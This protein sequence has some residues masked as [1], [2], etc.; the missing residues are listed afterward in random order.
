MRFTFMWLV[1]VG[2]GSTTPPGVLAYTDTTDTLQ[3]KDLQSGVAHSIAG[4]PYE[5]ISIDPTGSFVAYSDMAKNTALA[6]VS[7]G[8]VQPLE[9]ANNGVATLVEWGTGFLAYPTLVNGESN[10]ELVSNSG[11][12]IRQL[13]TAGPVAIAHDGSAIAYVQMTD[14]ATPNFTGTLVLEKPVGSAPTTVATN[15]ALAAFAFVDDDQYL[16]ATTLDAPTHALVIPLNGGGMTDLGQG[17]TVGGDDA[18]ANA[19]PDFNGSV[20]AGLAGQLVSVS[21]SDGVQTPVTTFPQALSS[22]SAGYTSTGDV[23]VNLSVDQDPDGDVEMLEQSSLLVSGGN[24]MMLASAAVGAVCHASAVSLAADS[25]ALECG[26]QD[27]VVK[28]T[29]GSQLVATSGGPFSFLGFGDDQSILVQ[30][31]D[32]GVVARVNFDGSIADLG[33]SAIFPWSAAFVR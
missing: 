28:T 11:T 24:Q 26:D 8:A 13:G 25:I 6:A 32:T 12:S 3:I 30:R 16:L 19:T 21:L 10:V 23:V 4:G 1:V 2:C 17:A 5:F 14:L 29:D 7:S 31:Q 27:L 15:I 20:L 33:T 18:I 22:W 9:P